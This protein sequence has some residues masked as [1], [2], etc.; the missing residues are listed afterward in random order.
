MAE[1]A[2]DLGQTQ[3]RLRLIDGAGA[4]RETELDGF[5]YGADLFETIV[6]RCRVAAASFGQT[7]IHA[8]AGGLTGLY[9]IVPDLGPLL[10]ELRAVLDVER[11]VLADDAV[12]S[13]LGALAGEPGA[14][15]AAG[16][17]IVGLGIGPSG[18]AR[19]DGVGSLIG[20]EGSGWWIGRRGIIAALS[21]YDGRSGASSLLLEALEQHYG[22]AARVPATIASSP[23]PVGLVASFAPAVAD[24][25]RRGDRV[26]AAIWN[27]AA[28]H[29]GD[30]VVAAGTRAGFDAASPFA[31]G[32]TGR[33]TLAADLL[34]PELDSL[35][36]SHFPAAVRHRPLGS[37]LD[38]AERLLHYP[39][40]ESLA[41]LVGASVIQKDIDD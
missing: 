35:V 27:E 20:D 9:G 1:L 26:A 38:G 37:G 7:T 33:L 24:A 3:T 34:D 29:I 21:A 4:R 16:T 14:L 23:F 17:G 2:F 41:P 19:I 15:V 10:A 31:W 25:A 11:V 8:V 6:D 36:Q 40:A 39:E 28:R 13:H 5:R 12:T 18:A 22:P 32:V 30:A